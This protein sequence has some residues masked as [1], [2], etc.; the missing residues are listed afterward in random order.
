MQTHR[1]TLLL[2]L[3]A[4][5]AFPAAAQTADTPQPAR[6]ADP[7]LLGRPSPPALHLAA[8]SSMRSARL[9]A[10]GA[11]DTGAAVIQLLDGATGQPLR[12]AALTYGE[13]PEL[14]C[15]WEHAFGDVG[16]AVRMLA[17]GARRNGDE[18]TKALVHLVITNR[19]DTAHTVS[20]AAQVLPGG[21]DPARRPLPSLPFRPGAVFA[22]EGNFIT[23]DGAVLLTWSGQEP[24][25]VDVLPP[26]AAADGPAVRLSWTL[27]MPPQTA[28]Y[29]DLFAAGPCASGST[30]E[31]AWRE[32]IAH[33]SYAQVEEQL[34]WQSRFR[35]YYA[36]FQSGDAPLRRAMIGSLHMLRMLGDADREF[37]EF[38][39]RPY[40]HPASD[41]GIPA[42]ALGLAAEWCWGDNGLALVRRLVADAAALG[43]DLPAARRVALVHGLARAV[44]LGSDRELATGLATAI[45]ALVT[46]PAEVEPW[47][48]PADVRA[49]LGSILDWAGP[50]PDGSDAGYALPELRWASATSG[51]VEAHMLAMRHA[52]SSGEDGRA[53][54]ECQAL[55]AGTTV[56]GFGTTSADGEPDGRFSLGFM[57]LVRSLFVEDHGDEL[58]LFPHVPAGLLPFP[59][60][61]DLAT[62]A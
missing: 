40:G 14:W 3:L 53:W 56:N 61:L 57:A 49:D 29:L 25:R 51:P 43:K 7:T 1:R 23:R 26:P 36:D 47:F 21:G 31:A 11:L 2:S 18:R 12:P 28:R 39:D 9:G 44:R 6:V 59:G 45:R 10:D 17:M 58:H 32:G 5:L 24:E 22:R 37:R 35:G 8:F 33:W 42:E 19:T 60:A 13:G 34:I 41:A 16:M 30:D 38:T 54:A 55:L 62:V 27:E 48:D 52:L 15:D 20:F 4:A 46:E 50:A